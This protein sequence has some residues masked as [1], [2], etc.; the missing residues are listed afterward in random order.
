[1]MIR[2]FEDGETLAEG[3][4]RFLAES[5]MN[6]LRRSLGLAGGSTPAATYEALAREGIDWSMVDLWMGDER[7]VP[8]D[9]PENNGRLASELLGSA[10]D[11]IQTILY[12]EGDDPDDAAL[13]YESKLRTVFGHTGGHADLVLLGLGNDGHTASLFPGTEALNETKRAYVSNWVPSQSQWRLT[14]TIP[15][16]TNASQLIFLVSGPSKAEAVRWLVKPQPGDPLVPARQIVLG[17]SDVL[18]LID[19]AAASELDENLY[20]VNR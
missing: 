12:H 16:L 14:A 1:M 20:F 10:S 9:S 19:R 11:R 18:L 5:L 15:L 13:V 17:S 7:W 6:G 4:A 8:S 3:A 2:V